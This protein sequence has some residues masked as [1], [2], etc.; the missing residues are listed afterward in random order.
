MALRQASEESTGADPAAAISAV[1][2]AL[3][4]ADERVEFARSQVRDLSKLVGAD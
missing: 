2:D 3:G 1:A 4:N